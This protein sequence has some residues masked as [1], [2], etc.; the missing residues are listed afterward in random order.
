MQGRGA[1]REGEVEGVRRRGGREGS[2]END[3]PARKM[4][5]QLNTMPYLC[6]RP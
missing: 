4:V 2:K 6:A 3:E 5:S 1:G